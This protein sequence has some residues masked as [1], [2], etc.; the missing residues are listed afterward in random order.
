[1]N[2]DWLKSAKDKEE[3]KK[4]VKSALPTLSILHALITARLEELHERR[5]AMQNYE[6]PSWPMLQ[7][8]FNGAER[9]LEYLLNLLDQE[10]LMK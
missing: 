7:A 2:S 3:R 1:M 4:Q 9:E 5:R 8:D 6:S 10:E